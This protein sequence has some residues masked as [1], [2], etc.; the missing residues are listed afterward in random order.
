MLSLSTLHNGNLICCGSFGKIEI[1]N[2]KTYQLEKTLE[3]HSR[4]F[5][6]MCFALFPNTG[7]ASGSYNG[8]I[9]IWG[10]SDEY[11]MTLGFGMYPP[12]LSLAVFPSGLSLA[13][14]YDDGMIRIWNIE[15]GSL[16]HQVDAH[17]Y[18]VR[19]VL[20]MLY[21]GLL[22]SGSSDNKIKF[23]NEKWSSSLFAFL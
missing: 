22:V 10:S 13:S 18:D 12:V 16:K 21:N 15:D 14:A 7:F 8:D 20:V 23:L 1:R 2:S 11:K 6:V 9:I 4:D 5:Y 17:E 3:R 19:T